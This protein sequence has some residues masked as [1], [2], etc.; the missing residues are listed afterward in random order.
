MMIAKSSLARVGTAV[1][2]FSSPTTAA[3]ALWAIFVI[4]GV[5]YATGSTSL[6]S[7]SAVH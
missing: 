5:L 6:Y 3:A 1:T 2:Q 7:M 4:S